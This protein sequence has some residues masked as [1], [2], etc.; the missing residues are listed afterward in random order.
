[1][2]ESLSLDFFQPVPPLPTEMNGTP[3]PVPKKNTAKQASLT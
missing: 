1:M 2:H 3:P